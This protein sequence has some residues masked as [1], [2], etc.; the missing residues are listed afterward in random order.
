MIANIQASSLHKIFKDNTF[1]TF[2]PEAIAAGVNSDSIIYITCQDDTS[3]GEKFEDGATFIWAKGKF[4]GSLSITDDSLDSTSLNPVQNKVI[5][6]QFNDLASFANAS[7]KEVLA[8][9]EGAKNAAKE[10]YELACAA[11]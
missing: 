1:K 3:F 2:T 8:V 7:Y 11:L 6:K 5:T 10:A 9:A 4:Y